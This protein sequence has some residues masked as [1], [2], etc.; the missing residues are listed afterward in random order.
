M[1]DD[2]PENRSKYVVSCV[3]GCE[4]FMVGVVIGAVEFEGGSAL[5]VFSH[6]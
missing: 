2:L 6:T 4:P 3:E 1:D 5:G